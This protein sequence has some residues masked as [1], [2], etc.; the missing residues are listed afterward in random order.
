MKPIAFLPSTFISVF[1]AL[2]QRKTASITKVVR[3]DD[4]TL[5]LRIHYVSDR[6][7]V[8]YENRFNVE[9][10][11]KTQKEALVR[12]ISDSLGVRTHRIAKP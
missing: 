8:N 1:A 3:D 11:T 9:G 4:K 6:R 10:W 5:I 7:E 12:R 2:T